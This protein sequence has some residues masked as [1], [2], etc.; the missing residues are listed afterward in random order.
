MTI[1]AE[2]LIDGEMRAIWIWYPKDRM[3][4][5]MIPQQVY[6][7]AHALMVVYEASNLNSSSSGTVAPQELMNYWWSSHRTFESWF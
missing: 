7:D 1:Q 2:Q 3:Q 4:C 6:I 5:R